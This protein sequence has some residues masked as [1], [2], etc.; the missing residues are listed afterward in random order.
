M[1]HFPK[2]DVAGSNPVSRSIFSIIYKESLASAN[3]LFEVTRYPNLLNLAVGSNL[4]IDERSRWID[5]LH[6]VYAAG[7]PSLWMLV[8]R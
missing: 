2:L 8:N 5:V 6:S 7:T 4:T 1:V 3:P